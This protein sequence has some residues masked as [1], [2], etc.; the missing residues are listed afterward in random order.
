MNK[1]MTKEELHSVLLDIMTCVD[2]FCEKNKIRY[3]L[4]GGTLL[5][6]IRHKGFIPWDDDLDIMM[7]RP[8]YDRFRM[9]F[10]EFN[11][12]YKFIYAEKSDCVDSPHAFGKVHDV[13]TKVYEAS[14]PTNKSGVYVDVFP[15]DGMP[16]NVRLCK[17]FIGCVTQFVQI[18]YYKNHR[19]S[20][21]PTLVAKIKKMISSLFSYNQ[22]GTFNNYI[23]SIFNYD[24]AEFAGAVTGVYGMKERY[25][26]DIF[27]HYI[28]VPFEDRNFYIIVDYDVYLEQH[29][30]NYMKLPPKDKQINH[31]TTAW[32]LI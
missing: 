8:D 22:L 12:N 16:T 26:K 7:P 4:G 24:K 23:I 11:P 2:E 5:G 19:Y 6:A 27:E 17:W 3:S 15:I 21:I 32:W 20:D 31:Q 13:R 29:Y 25:K 9:L 1:E 10:N 18:L 28:K 14:S 30:K